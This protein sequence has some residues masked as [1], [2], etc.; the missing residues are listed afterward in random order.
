MNKIVFLGL[1][2]YGHTNPSLG[3]VNELTKSGSKVYYF[4][5]PRFESMI[6]QAGGKYM[7]VKPLNVLDFKLHGIEENPF[8]QLHHMV[9]NSP[10]IVEN[11][12]PVIQ[13]INPD[14]IIYDSLVP[15]TLPILRHFNCLKVSSITTFAI[16]KKVI[17]KFI[18]NALSSR[19]YLK[20]M[21]NMFKTSKEVKNAMYKITNGTSKSVI[22]GSNAKGDINIVYTISQLQPYVK[23]FD[24]SYTFI[25]PTIAVRDEKI[26]FEIDDTKPLIYISL[27]TL[28]I[29][30]AFL[31]KLI[32]MLI[33][34]TSY[35][36]VLSVGQ[37][38]N[39]TKNALPSHILLR[40]FVP[41]LEVL[42]K[43]ALFITSCGMNSAHES[44]MYGVPIVGIPLT[45]EQAMVAQ[46]F[47]EQGAGIYLKNQNSKKILQA[48]KGILK[49]PSY[50]INANLLKEKLTNASGVGN[51]A[52]LIIRRLNKSALNRDE[53]YV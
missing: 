35:Q 5:I 18:F 28:L 10:E 27:G 40:K 16:N 37:K 11:L 50:K 21:I 26:D 52:S 45:A 3:L 44:A 25:G 41:Q 13:S 51:A 6:E 49:N 42:K 15:W 20:Q 31:D 46:A 17:G 8:K 34:E 30:N 24:S 2:S 48:I 53:V 19:K 33:P 39:Y 47:Q 36:V 14:C 22:G 38:Y 7:P 4:S 43:S 23:S 29:D 12:L 1:P 32:D 9:V